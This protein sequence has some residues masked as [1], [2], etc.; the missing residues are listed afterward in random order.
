MTDKIDAVKSDSNQIQMVS[1]DK[2]IPFRNHPFQSFPMAEKERMTESIRNVGILMPA[3]V[4]SSS[5]GNYEI[6]SGH[7]RMAVCKELGFSEIPVLIRE[8]SDEDAI[9]A[10]V[11]ANMQ[12]ENILPS[13]RAFAYKMK[14][15]ALNHRGERSDITFSQVRKKL[16][17]YE[18]IAME[19]GESRNQIYRYVRL[20][21]LHPDLLSMVDN[22][23]MALNP[24]V[25]LSFLSDDEQFYLID[26]MGLHDCTPS[27]SQAIR[28]K[29]LSKAG[30]LTEEM[31][32]EI[33]SERKPN[34]Q[35][36]IRLNREDFGRF[37]PSSYTETQIK[38]DVMKGLELL[39]RQRDRNSR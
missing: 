26:A 32:Y 21:Y 11:D 13:E 31:I 29:K 30:E 27:H 12:R 3:L 9:V 23:E 37:F 28:L 24:A 7:R 35:E 33:L 17:S 16:N 34:Q 5:D 36:K 22:G 2:L 4:R 20:T 15:D 14:L 25:E 1:L 39:K 8:M 19:G 38:R 10:M 6:I 18:L